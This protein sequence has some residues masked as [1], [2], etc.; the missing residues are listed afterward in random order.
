MLE[1][2]LKGSLEAKEQRIVALEARL[3]ESSNRNSEL[4]NELKLVKKDYEALKQRHKEVQVIVCFACLL[5]RIHE[6]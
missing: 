3:E 2:V 5:R 6:F 1:G 4:R